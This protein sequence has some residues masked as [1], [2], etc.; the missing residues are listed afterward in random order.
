LKIYN[1]EITNKAYDDMDQIYLHIANNLLEP[2]AAVNKYD[3]IADAIL[4]LDTMPDRIKIM[5][6]EPARTRGLRPLLVD[7][8]TVLFTIDS[9]TVYV[10]RVLYSSSDIS[11]R[12]AE[13]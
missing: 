5:D 3:K 10:V 2:I 8:Y 4:T 1:I 9:D 6:S 11:A 12:L 7:N 13:D